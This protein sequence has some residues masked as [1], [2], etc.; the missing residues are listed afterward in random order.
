M[1]NL[2]HVIPPEGSNQLYNTD[3]TVPQ[4][5]AAN[6]DQQTWGQYETHRRSDMRVT[7][8]QLIFA[9]TCHLYLVLI[10]HQDPFYDSAVVFLSK[11]QDGRS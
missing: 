10:V 2:D 9:V 5:A 11:E 8:I 7:S 1:V 3:A 6:P 4:T